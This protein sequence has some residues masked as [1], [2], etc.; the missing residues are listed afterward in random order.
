MRIGMKNRICFKIVYTKKLIAIFL[1]FMIFAICLCGGFTSVYKPYITEIAKSR[2]NNLV[3]QTVNET[4]LE[5]IKNEEY[6]GFV[7]IIRDSENKITGI[8]TNTVKINNFKATFLNEIAKKFK[9]IGVE[10][11]HISL[12]SFLNNPFLS[13]TSPFITIRVNPLSV[14]N[15]EFVNKFVSVGV[16]QTK[17]EIDLKCT[18]D[19][20]IVIPAISIK[21]SVTSVLPIAQTVIVGQVPQSYTNVSTDEENLNDTV[22]QLA[23]Y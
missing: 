11:Y 18:V 7:E 10:K 23:E 16:N 8:E 19:I 13:E 3:Q 4:V 17:H 12:F 14:I 5:I 20:I 22:L 2:A 1:I 9:E 6:S 15:A 21:H